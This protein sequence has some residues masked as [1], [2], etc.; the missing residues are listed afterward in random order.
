MFGTSPFNACAIKLRGGFYADLTARLASKTS[1]LLML[2]DTWQNDIICAVEVE[3][4]AQWTDGVGRGSHARG[5][6]ANRYLE[7]LVGLTRDQ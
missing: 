1:E 7:S 2:G 3:L 6:I 5:F 4:R